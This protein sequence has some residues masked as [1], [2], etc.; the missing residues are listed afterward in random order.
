MNPSYKIYHPKWHRERTPIFWWL[1]RFSYV[2]F[3]SRELT[4]LAVAYTAILLLLQ[5]WVV[6]RGAAAYERFLAL[7]ASPLAL[8]FHALILLALLFHTI[9]WLNLA[10]KA[11]V[12]HL[13]GRRLPDTAIVAVHYAAW[14]AATGLVAWWLLGV[15]R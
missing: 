7:L 3:I 5:I 12:F 4:S 2:K 9:T 8:A 15:G 6:S 1:K 11:L 14:L 10:P 13:R